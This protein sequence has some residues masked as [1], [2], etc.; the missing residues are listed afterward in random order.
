MVKQYLHLEH[1]HPEYTEYQ[2]YR[3]KLHISKLTQSLNV[4][5]SFVLILN[6]ALHRILARGDHV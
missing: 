4:I 6:S 5:E 2:K 1:Y 3:Q